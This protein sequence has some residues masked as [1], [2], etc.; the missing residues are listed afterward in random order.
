MPEMSKM[1]AIA[2]CWGT[3]KGM[4]LSFELGEHNLS[5]TVINIK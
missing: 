5:I 1:L 4:V 3:Y 2:I